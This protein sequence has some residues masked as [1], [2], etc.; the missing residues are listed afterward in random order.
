[1]VARLLV[2]TG[3]SNTLIDVGLLNQLGLQPTGQVDVSTPSTDGQ[4]VAML[5]YDVGLLLP[6]SANS[7]FFPTI[8]VTG[9]NFQAHGI[10][11]L[12]GRDVLAH[13]LVVYDGP[14][15]LYALAF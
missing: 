1:V 11:G 14:A 12:L 15:N 8:A 5:Q 4:P 13:C 9:A 7:R 6:H 10:H 3:A 2:D